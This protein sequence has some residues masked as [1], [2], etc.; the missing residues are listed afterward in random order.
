MVAGTY[1]NNLKQVAQFLLHNSNSEFSQCCKCDG[2]KALPSRCLSSLWIDNVSLH[3][4]RLW[5][6]VSCKRGFVSAWPSGRMN[7][8]GERAAQTLTSR[9]DLKVSQG[10]HLFACISRKDSVSVALRTFA[11]PFLSRP[12][13]HHICHLISDIGPCRPARFPDFCS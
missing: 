11:N 9:Y 4:T 13:I 2:N 8:D 5:P 12:S 7:A 3:L 10:W 6:F 1:L